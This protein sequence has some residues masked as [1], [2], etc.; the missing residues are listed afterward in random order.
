VT[1]P[2]PPPA[3]AER[4]AHLNNLLPQRLV[5]AGQ[6]A[7]TPR[8]VSPVTPLVHAWGNPAVVL[9]CGVPKPAGYS[10]RSSELTAVNGVR[11][12]EQISPDVVT[13]TAIRADASS[14][15]TVYLRL[16]VPS[17]YQGQGGFLVDLTEPVKTALP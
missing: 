16:V 7:L 9:S 2:Q 8:V 15:D 11:W 3:V 14:G 12:F 10:A 17:S 13:W 4:C 6:A 1:P 5:I